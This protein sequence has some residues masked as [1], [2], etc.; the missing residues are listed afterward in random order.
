M[1][2]QSVTKGI[3]RWCN[4][5]ARVIIYTNKGALGLTRLGSCCGFF[6]WRV[7]VSVRC[8]SA[9]ALFSAVAFSFAPTQRVCF[10]GQNR[11]VHTNDG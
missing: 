5:L 7:G 1:L 10:V 3:K 8:V 9:S 11:A 2:A 6:Q 4:I